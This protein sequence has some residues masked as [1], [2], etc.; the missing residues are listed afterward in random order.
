MEDIY[1]YIAP[2]TF[3]TNCGFG[4]MKKVDEIQ[5]IDDPSKPFMKRLSNKHRLNLGQ[6]CLVVP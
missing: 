4:A 2:Y 5:S 6:S 3:I 1:I